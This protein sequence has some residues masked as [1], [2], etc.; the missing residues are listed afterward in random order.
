MSY[1]DAKVGSSMDNG[2]PGPRDC[3]DVDLLTT[4]YYLLD[5]RVL[6]CVSLDSTKVRL[7]TG[8]GPKNDMTARDAEE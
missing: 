5:S 7:S 4:N 8:K 1:E 3:T 6:T 2:R